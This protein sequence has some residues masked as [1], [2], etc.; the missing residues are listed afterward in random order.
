MDAKVWINRLY[1]Y[2]EKSSIMNA[3]VWTSRL[4][5]YVMVWCILRYR[6]ADYMNIW[7]NLACGCYDMDKQII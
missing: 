5:E 7:G 3:K 4:Y 2:V 1:E 6:L